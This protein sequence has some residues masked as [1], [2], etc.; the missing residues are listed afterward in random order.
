MDGEE[1]SAVFSGSA[2]AVYRYM[3]DMQWV[4]DPPMGMSETLVTSADVRQGFAILHLAARLNDTSGLLLRIGERVLVEQ[5]AG[6]TRYDEISRT[7]VV[8]PDADALRAMS[9]EGARV[10]VLADMKFLILAA[11]DFYRRYGA[12]VRVPGEPR[13]VVE[14]QYPGVPTGQQE[15]AALAVASSSMSY[16]WGAPGTG[17]TQF[18]L[19]SCIRGCLE[20]GERVAVFAP[21]NNSVEQVLRGILG[22]FGEDGVPKGIVRLGVPTKGFLAEHPEMCEDN[23]AQMRIDG[24]ARSIGNLEEVLYE[25]ACDSIRGELESLM[26][27]G[28]VDDAEGYADGDPDR[29]RIISDIR[30]VASMRPSTA[31][32]MADGVP[33][34]EAAGSLYLALFDRERPA[35]EI[36]EYGEWSTEEISA[37]ISR[38]SEEMSALRSRS[39]GNRIASAPIIAATPHQFISRFRPKG[40]P[41][42]GRM[43]LDVDRIFL[44]EA[45]YCGLVQALALFTNG[46]PVAMFGDHMQLPPVTQLDEALLMDRAQSGGWL[47]DAFIWNMSALHCET[48]LTRGLVDLRAEYISGSGPFFSATVRRDLTDSRRFGESLARVLDRY[49]YRNGMTGSSGTDMSI[50]CIDVVCGERDTR[51]NRAEADAIARL[52]KASSPDPSDV[53]ILS[54]YTAQ[55]RL[56]RSKVGRRYADCVMTVHGSQGREWDTVVLSVADSGTVNRDVPL[57]FTSSET[58]IGRRVINTAVSRA[59]RRLVVVCDVGFWS[60][61]EGELIRG[62]IEAAEGRSLVRFDAQ[63]QHDLPEL[64]LDVLQAV[65]HVGDLRAQGGRLGLELGDPLEIL[66]AHLRGPLLLLGCGADLPG[67][68]DEGVPPGT[69]GRRHHVELLDLVGVALD[70]G[71]DPAVLDGCE[72]R[73]DAADVLVD[74]LDGHL[75]RL[76]AGDGLRLLGPVD[77]ESP[78]VVDGG[79]HAASDVGDV[80]PGPDEGV[81]DLA[82]PSDQGGDLVLDAQHLVGLLGG[83]GGA[84]GHAFCEVLESAVESGDLGIDEP[85]LPLVLACGHRDHFFFFFLDFFSAFSA[86]MVLKRS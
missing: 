8:R 7:I 23:Q 85:K 38:L 64:L 3:E 73:V 33:L 67:G 63:G 48:V 41:E 1:I 6:F 13:T 57:R 34:S 15:S 62:L 53:C 84:V 4:T 47:S 42:D 35:A 9:E 76:E 36:A 19:A 82:L 60:A 51:E 86:E 17:K 69:E 71:S 37:E 22:A 61:R 75:R 72:L 14:P 32:I 39:T 81:L 49:V 31:S 10:S 70:L 27:S 46:V 45:G 54:P 78:C 12:Y 77:L 80:H 56:L 66:A 20:A 59:R 28:S 74:A 44:D 40:S 79:V 83:L 58:P 65:P 30:E 11:G 18:V 2:D 25:R 55:C 5:D 68:L 21:T 52:L 16:V 29:G 26:S 43:E 50:E 24:C